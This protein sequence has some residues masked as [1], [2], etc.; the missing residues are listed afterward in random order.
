[1][2]ADFG[3]LFFSPPIF[4]SPGFGSIS[5]DDDED[6]VQMFEQML[7][8]DGCDSINQVRNYWWFMQIYGMLTKYN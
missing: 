2:N 8:D 6:G 5:D 4:L 7:I 3:P 1:M